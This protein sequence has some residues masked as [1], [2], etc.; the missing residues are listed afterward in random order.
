[1]IRMTLGYLPLDGFLR[2]NPELY[3]GFF[4]EVV[5]CNLETNK[6]Q[7]GR[8]LIPTKKSAYVLVG[9]TFTTFRKATHTHPPVT[10]VCRRSQRATGAE[11]TASQHTPFPRLPQGCPRAGLS[12]AL[13]LD[14][15]RLPQCVCCTGGWR[16]RDECV[17]YSTCALCAFW[18]KMAH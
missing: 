2:V 11:V 14:E 18:F 3:L 8:L 7:T 13:W 16:V 10:D 12:V 5:F 9:T 4:L 6:Q 15:T 1:M 17:V